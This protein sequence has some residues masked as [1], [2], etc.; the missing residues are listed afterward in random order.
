VCAF[1]Q[2][3]AVGPDP[4]IA[5]HYALINKHGN[6]FPSRSYR[7]S[8]GDGRT[9]PTVN[10]ISTGR[11][12]GIGIILVNSN[13]LASSPGLRQRN[14]CNLIIGK[15]HRAVQILLFAGARMSRVHT[16]VSV[17]NTIAARASSR[18][19]SARNIFVQLRIM[20]SR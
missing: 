17:K 9:P 4:V 16:V 20:H 12:K 1:Q 14:N 15:V 10:R 6:L 5:R 7:N 8:D 19:E 13:L 18:D 11:I 3:A 2:P